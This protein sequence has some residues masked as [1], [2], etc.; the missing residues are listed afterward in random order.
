MNFKNFSTPI[1]IIFLVLGLSGCGMAKKT[2]TEPD[3]VTFENKSQQFSFK[4]P[5]EW[6]LV[7]EIEK[8]SLLTAF[9]KRE[10]PS[11]E[12]VEVWNG[13]L[14]TPIYQIAIRAEDNPKNL[15]A[16]E[17]ELSRYPSG[18]EEVGKSL[19][20]I[21][22]AGVPGFKTSGPIT[23]PGSGPMTNIVLAPGNGKIYSF[24]YTADAYPQTHEKFLPEFNQ[25]LETLKFN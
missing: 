16:R 13:E 10:D 7:P 19:E 24:V 20:D 17:F 15:S 12:K 4:Y 1:L 25:I 9:L 14:I 6:V 21:T 2:D 8:E 3:W 5:Q 23:P 18:G 22:I 11:Q